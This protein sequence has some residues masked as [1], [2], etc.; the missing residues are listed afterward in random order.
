MF[1]RNLLKLPGMKAALAALIATDILVALLTCGQALALGLAIAALW[2]GSPLASQLPAIGAFLGCFAGRQ[3]IAFLREEALERYALAATASLRDRLLERTF[4]QRPLLPAREGSAA[5]VQAATE[6]IDQIEGYIRM[7]PPK[8]CGL[9]ALAL[10]LA[11]AEL[12]LDWISGLI[13]LATTPV[14]FYFMQLLGRQARDRAAAQYDS[15]RRLSNHFIDTLRGLPTLAAFRR[16]AQEDSRIF[17]ASEKLRRA[18][19]GTIATATLSSALLDLTAT[20]GVAAVAMMLAF[21]LMDGSMAL[22]TALTALMLAPEFYTPLRTFAADFHASLDAKQALAN[23]ERLLDA[24]TVQPPAETIP[25]WGEGSA[26]AAR[27][28]GFRYGNGPGPAAL[29]DVSFELPAGR[30]LAVIGPSGSGKSTLADL[31]AGF[32]QPAEGD[33]S[34]DGRTVPS[35]DGPG[36]TSQVHYIPQHPFIFRGSLRDNVALY[37]PGASDEAVRA[38]LDTVGLGPLADS[39]P[40]G[41]RSPIG[42]G[43]RGLSGGQAQRI[44]LARICLDPRPILVFDEPT[45]HLDI[46]TELELKERILPLMEGRTV[47]F[48]THRLHWLDAMDAVLVLDGGRVGAREA[49][50]L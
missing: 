28:L 35:L 26:L 34:I 48:A 10:P 13:L 42:D 31:V 47:L 7:M 27:D 32:A 37:S 20:L 41:I 12:A 25:A 38:A 44:A 36:W 16:D 19:M 14:I 1:D 2:A 46:E 15:Y 50:G 24:P 9:V 17:D 18:S 29:S 30:R 3:V 40:E 4:L 23:L 6:G 21:R 11:A 8:L 49:V 39:L 45:A 43:G 22:A 33:F 5:V